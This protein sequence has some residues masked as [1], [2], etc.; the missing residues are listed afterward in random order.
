M[1]CFLRTGRAGEGSS[2]RRRIGEGVK[3]NNRKEEG[4]LRL[5]TISF[6][7]GVPFLVTSPSPDLMCLQY[8]ADSAH[9]GYLVN[10]IS[11]PLFC[12]DTLPAPLLPCSPA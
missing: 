6:L 12:Q 5:A 3:S 2:W 10:S 1:V 11:L 7:V 9:C 8:L 4:Q